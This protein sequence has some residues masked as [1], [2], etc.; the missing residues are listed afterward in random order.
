MA[1]RKARKAPRKA[2]KPTAQELS[3]QAYAAHRG[4]SRQ[5]VMRALEEGRLGAAV[6]RVG[7]RW[8]IQPDLADEAWDQSTDHL[9]H[10]AQAA[11][12]RA[13]EEPA[14]D[15]PRLTLNEARILRETAA[16]EKLQLEVRM[17]RRELAEADLIE[18]VIF[19]FARGVREQLL[20]VPYRISEELAAETSSA[21]VEIILEREYSEVLEKLSK[22]GA[23][24]VARQRRA[25]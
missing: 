8:R 14:D 5:S 20:A 11:A 24:A 7:R 10:P 2:K 4:V 12:A 16:A 19:D 1:K 13:S 17:M 23:Q 9:R 18:R 15:E 6:R 3:P 25:G 21:G 22:A